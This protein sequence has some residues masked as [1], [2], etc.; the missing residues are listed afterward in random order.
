MEMLYCSPL[1]LQNKSV[2]LLIK[3]QKITILHSTVWSNSIPEAIDS[4]A[5]Y[6]K[7]RDIVK[8]VLDKIAKIASNFAKTRGIVWFCGKVGT[9][10]QTLVYEK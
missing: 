1:H 8:L 7:R 5:L 3:W 6:T 4:A 2:A 9:S 10:H